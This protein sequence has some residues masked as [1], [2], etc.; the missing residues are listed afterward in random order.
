VVVIG[1]VHIV[2]AQE[3]RAVDASRL[4]VVVGVVVVVV[5]V[6]VDVTVFQRVV[7]Q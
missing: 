6:A 4:V 2:E 5:V 1:G 7:T 3:L